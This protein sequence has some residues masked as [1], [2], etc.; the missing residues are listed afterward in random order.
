MKHLLG[1]QHLSKRDIALIFD[2]ATRF[3]DILAR[4]VKTVPSL[5]DITIANLF[6]ENSTR[7]RLSFELAE[8][9]LSAD[10]VNFSP[11]AS[12]LSKGESLLDTVRSILHMKVDILVVR[13]ESPGVPH[14]LSKKLGVKIVNAGDGSHEHPTQALLDA[15]SL[16]EKFSAPLAG[17]KIL[18]LGDIIHSRVALSNM[19]CLKKCGAEVKVCAPETLIPQYVEQLGVRVET[20]LAKALSWCEAVN[21]LRV[22]L[23]RQ[24][25]AYFPSLEE[26]ALHYGLSRRL[27]DAIPHEIIVLHPGP[28]NRGVEIDSDVADSSQS[29][30]FRQ[31]E[32]GVAIRMA[33]LYLLL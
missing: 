15:F 23:E 17:R 19:F 14:F 27:L 7:T 18:I 9:R 22:Q 20:D 24:Q 11:A 29:I 5:K 10:V 12:S 32:N 30:V 16:Q 33:V 2:T 13:H 26:Y 21:V 8:K 25:N 1:I 31:V 6:F 4:R 3:K 28:M